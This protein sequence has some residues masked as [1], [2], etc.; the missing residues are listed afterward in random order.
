M[1]NF[2]LNGF[3]VQEMDAKGME[4][5]NGGFNDYIDNGAALRHNQMRPSSRYSEYINVLSGYFIICF[6]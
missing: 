3:G 6:G 2:D 4:E 1:K 5:V